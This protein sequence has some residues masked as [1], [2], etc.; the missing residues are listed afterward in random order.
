[1]LIIAINENIHSL[2][3]FNLR[4]GTLRD[5]Q[6][7]PWSL[8]WMFNTSCDFSPWQGKSYFLVKGSSFKSGVFSVSA[9]TVRRGEEVLKGRKT[10]EG[11]LEVCCDVFLSY[12]RGWWPLTFRGCRVGLSACQA[13]PTRIPHHPVLIRS[14]QIINNLFRNIWFWSLSRIWIEI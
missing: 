2:R 7:L 9:I 14:K 10:K 6:C 5:W 4:L 8:S 13:S 12:W 1:M 11:I 3:W